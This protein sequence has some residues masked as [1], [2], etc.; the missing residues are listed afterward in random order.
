MRSVIRGSNPVKTV[1]VGEEQLYRVVE[2]D[3]ELEPM[4]GPCEGLSP[5]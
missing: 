5:S 1:L 4:S 3:V 2:L